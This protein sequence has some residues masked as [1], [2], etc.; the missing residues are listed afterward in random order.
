MSTV[1]RS[2]SDPK[3]TT[4]RRRRTATGP[5]PVTI[6][7]NLVGAEA[8]FHGG[9]SARLLTVG[10]PEISV[11]GETMRAGGNAGVR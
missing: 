2:T 5:S 1:R 10:D 9:N 4:G 7:G 3:A 6:V 11:M 8:R